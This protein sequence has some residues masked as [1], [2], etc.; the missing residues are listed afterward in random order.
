MSGL[1]DNHCKYKGDVQ[2]DPIHSPI[3]NLKLM[4]RQTFFFGLNPSIFVHLWKAFF[5]VADKLRIAK[6]LSYHTVSMEEARLLPDYIP[7]MLLLT[8]ICLPYLCYRF[9]SI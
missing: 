1:G 5:K 6:V 3:I 9:F 4:N 8:Y 2:I 7:A